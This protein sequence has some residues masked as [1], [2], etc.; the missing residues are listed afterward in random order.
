MQRQEIIAL[1]ERRALDTARRLFGL[2]QEPLSL[3]AGLRGLR[4]PGLQRPA[5][6]LSE[7]SELS[8]R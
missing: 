8:K 4:Q 6:D 1:V 3:V 5:L 2:S 7:S